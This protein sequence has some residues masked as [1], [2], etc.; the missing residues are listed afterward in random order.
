MVSFTIRLSLTAG[1]EAAYVQPYHFEE[2]RMKYVR[3]GGTNLLVSKFCLGTMMFGGKTD[4]SEAV[5]IIRGA[6]DG[7][8]NFIDTAN[9]YTAG[10]SEEITGEAI[11]GIRDQV[12]LASKV[13]S[14]MS[15]LPNGSGISRYTIIGGV[16][17]SLRRLKTDRIDLLYIH[18]PFERMNLEEMTRALEDLVRQGKILYPGCSNFPA[19][20]SCRSMWI[21]DLNGYVPMAAC[22]VPYNMIER[23]LE[24]E[25]LPMADALGLGIVCYRPLG[26]GFLTGRYLDAD[27]NDGR[28]HGNEKLKHWAGKYN[29]GIGKLRDYAADKGFTTADAAIAWVAYRRGVTSALVGISRLEQVGLNLKAFEWEMT[30]EEHEELGSFFPTEVWEEAWSKF[31]SWRRSYDIAPGSPI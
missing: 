2:E 3:L 6:V 14:V 31:P 11:K 24:V 8:V 16:E 9:I 20:L 23:G 13:G 18:W 28:L 29:E 10:K 27:P 21:Q 7:G 25:I 4:R 15:D 30:R 19:W 5:K 22:Q 1:P 26:V 17:A 12:V